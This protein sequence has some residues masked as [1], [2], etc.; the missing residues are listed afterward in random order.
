LWTN[1]SNQEET[2]DF[3][4]TGAEIKA[5]AAFA[6]NAIL[7]FGLQLISHLATWELQMSDEIITDS[8]ENNFR[9]L[10]ISSNKLAGFA[11]IDYNQRVGIC[12]TLINDRTK[13]STFEHDI[14]S[15]DIS[16]NVYAKE[17][18]IKNKEDVNLIYM[19][20]EEY[21]LYIRLT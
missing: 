1:A 2:A 3:N 10:N 19:R 7:F 5:P 13:L 16:L 14:T 20:K 11:L 9:R 21:Y 12:T 6:V 17:E 8:A 15:K 18:R 4:M